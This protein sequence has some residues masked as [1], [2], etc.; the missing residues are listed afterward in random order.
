MA[1]VEVQLPSD[2]ERGAVGGPMFKTRVL[3]L[4]SGHEQRNIDW[5][6]A[7]G[8]WDISYGLMSLED[9]QLGTYIHLVRDFFYARVG[10]AHSFNFKDWTDFEIGKIA[11]ATVDNQLIALGDDATVAFQIFKRYS[12]GGVNHDR[13]IEKIVPA[14]AVVL[15]DNVAQTEGADYAL[16]D[17]T[18][19]ITMVVAPASTGGTGPGGEEVL[20][21]A[22]EFLVP[23]RFD[24][25]H[26]RI[27]IEN[28]QAGAVPSIPVVE[29]RIPE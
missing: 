12:S 21:V 15:L 13:T 5:S 29:I 6:Q 14:T 2:I 19:I 1:H 26:L 10:R 23:V 18:G 25:D 11:T 24:D 8:E 17:T 16:D 9:N 22:L 28:F 7:R 4:E 27:N 20:A 3:G